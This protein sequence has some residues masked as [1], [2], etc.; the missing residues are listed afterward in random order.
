M[1]SLL[2]IVSVLG[3]IYWVHRD[4]KASIEKFDD[5]LHTV[6]T[7]CLPTLQRTVDNLSRDVE[8]LRK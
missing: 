8:E 1:E 5:R 4:L 6:Q 2:V 7:N 3:G